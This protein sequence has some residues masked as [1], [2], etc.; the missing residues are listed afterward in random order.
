[1]KPKSAHWADQAAVRVIGVQGDQSRYTVA[2][3]ITPSGTVHIGNFREVITTHLVAKALR[4]LG[5]E[6]RFIYSWDNFDTFRKVPKNLP[7]QDMLAQHLRRP[8]SR[9]PDPYQEQESYAAGNIKRFEKEMDAIGIKPEY[10][11]QE[12]RYSQGL[13]AELMR[14]ALEQKETIREILDSYRSEP[15]PKDWLPTTL[16]CEKCG[17]D[18]IA[19]QRYEPGS[20]DYSYACGASDCQYEGTLD[21]RTSRNLKLNWRIDWPMR[22]VYEGVDFEPGG[23]DHSS[24][25]GSYATGKKITSAV[26]GRAAPQ[27]LQY[28][29]VAIKGGAGK[30]SSSSGELLT[31]SEAMAVYDPLMVRWIFATQRPNHDFCIALDVDVIKTYDEFDRAEC[32]ALSPPPTKLGRWPLTRR[33]YEL[34][35][36]GELP[37]KPP[38]RAPFRELC[39]RLQICDGDTERTREKFYQDETKDSC[40][41]KAFYDRAQCAL[42]WLQHHAP[43]EFRYQIN[44]E[45]VSVP[46]EPEVGVAIAALK[47]LIE[48]LELSSIEAKELNQLIYDQV[49][50]GTGVESKAFFAA[51]YQKLIS[52]AQG[53]RLPGFLKEIGKDRLISLL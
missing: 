5:K 50:R 8:I 3:G 14:N 19:W 45:S 1:M 32:T 13:Y 27:Y 41:L 42:F 37:E 47:S 2:S 10:L 31:L 36:E 24:D 38:F 48:S 20:W 6:V 11:Y 25:G 51:V 4:D 44:K 30:M 17:R 35:Y 40:D 26:W 39:N 23:K 34:A 9:V 16:Y 52:R 15:L 53:P 12:Q 33:T 29:F 18:T 22:W 7:Q 21:M 46:F 43:E 49:I 28:D